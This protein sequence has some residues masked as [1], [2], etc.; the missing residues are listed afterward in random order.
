M[1]SCWDVLISINFFWIKSKNNR[2]R[3][4]K[5]KQQITRNIPTKLKS[6]LVRVLVACYKILI[7]SVLEKNCM[8]DIHEEEKK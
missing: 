3:K 1:V 5:T 6:Q 7:F 4:Q 2:K 8:L